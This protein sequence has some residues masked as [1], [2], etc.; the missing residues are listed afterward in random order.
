[1]VK[2]SGRYVAGFWVVVVALVVS[3]CGPQQTTPSSDAQP[4]SNPVS[5]VYEAEDLPLK[6]NAPAG[7]QANCCDVVWSNNAQVW[8]RATDANQSM[9]MEFNVPYDDTYSISA[10]QTRS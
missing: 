3:A 9:S 7:T 6:A 5:L 10:V 2:T 8:F 1:M 4:Q